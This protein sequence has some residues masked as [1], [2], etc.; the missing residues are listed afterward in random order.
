MAITILDRV[1]DELLEDENALT[2]SQLLDLM[3]T[4]FRNLFP[5]LPTS[6]SL[7]TNDC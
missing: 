1:S 5:S 7:G 6:F 2:E 3:V 4:S